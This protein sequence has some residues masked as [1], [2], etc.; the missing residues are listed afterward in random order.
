MAQ[1][2]RQ[3]PP[4]ELSAENIVPN[5][6]ISI[7]MQGMLLAAVLFVV[8]YVRRVDAVELF[9]LRRLRPLEILIWTIG[10]M[11]VAYPL[12]M[13]IGTGWIKL[14]E[15]AL[16]KEP[17]SQEMVTLMKETTNLPVK[18]LM[19][20]SAVVVAPIAE[21]ILFRGY[22]YPAV[23]RFSER[24]FAAIIISL[25][26]AV[27]HN[28]AMSI[29]PLFVLAMALTIAYEL[30]GCLLVPILMHALFNLSQVIFI[31]ISFDG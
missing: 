26:F 17:A 3:S 13:V 12:M 5:L 16:G 27:V 4:P 21:E 14:L 6:L 10:A 8:L 31:F 2:I 20:F 9:G 29:V 15:H 1:H 25:L 22:F 23:K 30:T 7:V 11:A 18:L 19:A 28:N 24:Y